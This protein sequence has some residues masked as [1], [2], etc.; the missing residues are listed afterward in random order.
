MSAFIKNIRLV[1][2]F[3]GSH[4]GKQNL[5]RKMSKNLV[6]NGRVNENRKLFKKD[7]RRN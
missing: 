5:E 4:G 3:W 7:E 6:R 1:E 2:Y